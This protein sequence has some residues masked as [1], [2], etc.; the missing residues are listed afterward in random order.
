MWWNV[1][2]STTDRTKVE[3][4]IEAEAGATVTVTARHNRAGT[5]HAELVL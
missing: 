2:H 4:V 3:W 1:D 5:V